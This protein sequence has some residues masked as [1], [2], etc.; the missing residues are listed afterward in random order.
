MLR[1]LVVEDELPIRSGLIAKIE[2][3][4][5]ETL[6]ISGEASDGK[7]ALVWL[8]THYADIC[9]TDIRMPIM[10]GLEL[11]NEINQSY[12]WMKCIIVS[13]YDDFSYAKAALA[14]H[15][16]DYILK[17]VERSALRQALE[18]AKAELHKERM[19]R[20]HK[21]LA[22]QLN[23]S[24]EIM[25]KW[26]DLI[27]TQQSDKYP[28]LVM[29]TLL[30][31]EQW[32]GSDYYLL[33]PLSEAWIDMIAKEA[34]LTIPDSYSI[35]DHH[36][37]YGKSGMPHQDKRFYF[38]L[39]AV[40]RLEQSMLQLI[41]QSKKDQPSEYAKMVTQVKAY[42]EQHFYEKI[43]ASEL[44]DLIPISRSYLAVLFKQHTGST[45]LGYLTEVRMNNAK[46][47][48]LDQQQK[49]YEI[50]NQVGYENS[51]HFAKIFKD[52][53]GI[54]PKEYRKRMGMVAEA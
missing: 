7:E 53:C 41:E 37:G 51:E 49:I 45:L 3:C 18:S 19:D 32:S 30:A 5:D 15:V 11:I 1:I 2:Q 20:A 43:N 25:K 31:M 52:F 34:R 27:R 38:R 17:P 14:L 8:E 50:A 29:D 4:G 9:I 47:L 21:L 6:R 35:T 39:A 16:T 12:P 22:E 28:L 44:A 13:S 36:L 33:G 46:R 42:I 26:V 24:H 40:M 10:D 23:H 54:T 48:L